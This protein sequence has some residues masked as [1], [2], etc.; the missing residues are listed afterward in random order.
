[1]HCD[2][3]IRIDAGDYYLGLAANTGSLVTNAASTPWSD[4]RLKDK[5]EDI[6]I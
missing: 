5:I 6:I 4:K 3:G 2:G 1:M